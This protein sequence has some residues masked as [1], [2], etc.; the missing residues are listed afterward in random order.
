MR[1][2]S[3][4]RTDSGGGRR[5]GAFAMPVPTLIITYPRL[6]VPPAVQ[7]REDRG[8]ALS[9]AST[10]AWAAR[11]G[12]HAGR[13]TDGG[14]GATGLNA[15]K[16]LHRRL[17]EIQCQPQEQAELRALAPSANKAVQAMQKLA[18][19]EA[20]RADVRHDILRE[21]VRDEL[22]DR[23]ANAARVLDRQRML[24]EA[25]HD[26]ARARPLARVARNIENAW[27]RCVRTR[28]AW[29][30]AWPCWP[31][32]RMQVGVPGERGARRLDVCV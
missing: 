17:A 12:Q 1:L 5:P 8:W 30:P 14:A 27:G 21:A 2:P 26:G 28:C 9:N 32:R 11:G 13:P 10:R 3:L 31:W 24:A 22:I 18:R 6:G 29:R 20:V 16:T 7:R 23:E 15:T 19:D 25:Q 4:V